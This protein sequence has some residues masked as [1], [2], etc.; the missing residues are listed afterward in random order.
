MDDASE[1][2]PEYINGRRVGPPVCRWHEVNINA[3]GFSSDVCN[4]PST[5]SGGQ[6]LLCRVHCRAISKIA[7]YVTQEDAE[8]RI[9][10]RRKAQVDR[11]TNEIARL[12][13]QVAELQ[14]PTAREPR[15]R[16][17]EGSVY[18]LRVGGLIKIGWTSDLERRMREYQPDSRLLAVFPG[19]VKNEK[20]L[21]RKFSHLMT[22]GRE[23]FPIAPQIEEEIARVVAEF[24]PPPAVDFSARSRTRKVAPKLKVTDRGD[25]H[26]GAWGQATG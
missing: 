5:L 20:A 14:N 24:G 9:R 10:N 25:Q 15:K 3:Y 7:G 11:L 19:T 16:P 23:W 8:E 13:K 12:R 21:H 22:H 17:T 1:Y 18:F 26:H 2:V 6:L 4:R